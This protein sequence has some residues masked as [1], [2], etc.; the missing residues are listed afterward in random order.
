MA[1]ELVSYCKFPPLGHRSAAGS[2]VQLGYQPLPMAES[3]E[4]INRQTLVV[5]MLESPQAIENA[6]A[7]AA[8]EGVDVLLIG[9][10]DLCMEMGIPQ[11]FGDARVDAAMKATVEACKKHGK[12]P[13]FGG[14]YDEE[15]APRYIDMG[16][17]FILSG[18][19]LNYVIAGANQRARFLRGLKV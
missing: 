7:I 16:M 5:V 6:D 9:T 13:G 1:R 18:G 10:N 17:R 8:V 4:L 19:D 12:I 15:H 2:P 11:Q 14:V 3:S